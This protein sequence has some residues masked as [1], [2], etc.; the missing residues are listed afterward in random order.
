MAFDINRVVVSA[1]NVIQT[2]KR[3]SFGGIEMAALSY[4]IEGGQRYF[5]HKYPKVDAGQQ[6]K[7]GRTP[8]TFTATVVFDTNNHFLRSISYPDSLAALRKL[9]ESGKTDTLVVPVLKNIQA[10][11]SNWTENIDAHILSGE[12]VDLTFQEDIDV[13]TNQ[14][15][16]TTSDVNLLYSGLAAIQLKIPTNLPTYQKSLF[17]KLNDA[18]GAVLGVVGLGS[19]YYGLVVSK[20][21]MV[22]G[23]LSKIDSGVQAI[24]DP[25]NSALY[26]ALQALWATMIDMSKTIQSTQ[27]PMAVFIVPMTMTIQAV[28]TAIYGDTS[29]VSDLLSFNN[30]ADTFHIAAGTAIF[31]RTV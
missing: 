15:A 25:T 23:L 19:A 8:Y 26:E 30:V 27:K 14:Q 5:T 2:F 29:Q 22:T 4:R 7:L 17:D 11:C 10:F 13:S 21:A 31:Y 6:E 12:I 9:L 3:F 16:I 20:I 1:P 18:V 28:S 24:Q